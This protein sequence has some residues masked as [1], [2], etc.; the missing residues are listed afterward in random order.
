MKVIQPQLLSDEETDS[1]YIL[2]SSFLKSFSQFLGNSKVI[3]FSIINGFS[4]VPSWFI[5]AIEII[6][7][8]NLVYW[9]I[10]RLEFQNYF[11]VN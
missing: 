11:L 7:S 6:S 4:I 8:E 1:P 5:S 3:F 10:L 9:I 2:L